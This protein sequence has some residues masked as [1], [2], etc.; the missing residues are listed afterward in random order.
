MPAKH[1]NAPACSLDML[2]SSH[3]APAGKTTTVR[4][5]CEMSFNRVGMPLR[6]EGE[7]VNEVRTQGGA[8]GY[9]AFLLLPARPRSDV[10]IT[11]LYM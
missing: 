11:A 2:C 5:F 8:G 10:C 3:A 7:G 6:W 4:A 1:S 9:C